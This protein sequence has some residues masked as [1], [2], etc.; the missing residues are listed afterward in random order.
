MSQG[1]SW[2]LRCRESTCFVKAIPI[3]FSTHRYSFL[4]FTRRLIF[5]YFKQSSHNCGA[6]IPE[7]CEAL[8]AHLL[9]LENARPGNCGLATLPASRAQ[10]AVRSQ[11]LS[12]Y[13][14]GQPQKRRKRSIHPSDLGPFGSNLSQATA[15]AARTNSHAPLEPR[16]V[17]LQAA[18]LGLRRRPRP[19]APERAPVHGNLTHL[20]LPA[21]AQKQGRELSPWADLR[22]GG[23]R[24]HGVE[25]SAAA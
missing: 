4:A 16:Q 1:T 5:W 12:A 7:P 24:R 14:H 19:V 22:T 18:Y 17:R 9:N 21:G 2:H 20:R 8:V 6:R 23:W 13:P 3:V 15:T 10:Q 25:Q 11:K